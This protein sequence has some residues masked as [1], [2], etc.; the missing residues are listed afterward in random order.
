MESGKKVRCHT[1]ANVE[2]FIKGVTKSEQLVLL[3]TQRYHY[4]AQLSEYLANM[5]LACLC[6]CVCQKSE[7]YSVVVPYMKID[8]HFYYVHTK[9]GKE[10]VRGHAFIRCLSW[11][12]NGRPFKRLLLCH[13][14]YCIDKHCWNTFIYTAHIKLKIQQISI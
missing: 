13:K 2:N 11:F 12:Q 14:Q 5:R 8:R 1:D 6:V 4:Y 10:N 3:Q 9:K 7:M